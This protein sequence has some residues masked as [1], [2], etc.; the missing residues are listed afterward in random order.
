MR[1]VVR[2]RLRQKNLGRMTS[3]CLCLVGLG[4]VVSQPSC[5][6]DPQ[7]GEHTAYD[8]AAY[9]EDYMRSVESERLQRFPG[10][11]TRILGGETVPGSLTEGDLMMRTYP[12][13]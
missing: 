9:G 7:G 10:S 3:A 8:R 1:S 2:C 5:S 4:V 6:T 13:R 12:R 11:G